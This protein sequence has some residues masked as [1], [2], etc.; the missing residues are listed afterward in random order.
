MDDSLIFF[1]IYNIYNDLLTAVELSA[2]LYIDDIILRSDSEHTEMFVILIMSHCS[3]DFCINLV[4]SHKNSK[5][6]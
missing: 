5:L 1:I 4:P 6:E 2:E 3:F